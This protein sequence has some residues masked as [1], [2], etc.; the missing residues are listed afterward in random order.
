MDQKKY[1]IDCFHDLG[2]ILQ[3]Q[4]QYD[5]YIID[6][7]NDETKQPNGLTAGI[8]LKKHYPKSKI[9]FICAD[10]RYEEQASAARVSYYL[11]GNISSTKLYNCFD[12]IIDT[13]KPKRALIPTPGLKEEVILVEEISYIDIECRN[14][15][16]HFKDGS[17]VTSVAIRSAFKKEVSRFINIGDLFFAAPTLMVNID[18]IKTLCKN[19]IVFKNGQEIYTTEKAIKLIREEILNK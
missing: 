6:I 11:Y 9:I 5:I 10:D 4:R 12:Q 1:T 8:E 3:A 13:V 18:Y 17:K 7:A 2:Q 14:I 19:K 15:C 16:F